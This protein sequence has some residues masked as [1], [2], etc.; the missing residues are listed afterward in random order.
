MSS[1]EYTLRQV[2]EIITGTTDPAVISRVSRQVRH[3]TAED[4]VPTLGGKHGGSG[5]HRRYDANAVRRAAITLE[6]VRYGITITSLEPFDEYLDD[7]ADHPKWEKAVSG[8][9]NVFLS[10][11]IECVEDGNTPI[12]LGT[13]DEADPLRLVEA[14]TEEDYGRGLIEV[15]NY[16]ST[17]VINLTKL[18]ARLDL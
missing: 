4:I 12:G 11:S 16:A 14:Q 18:F 6:L 9:E 8:G 3:W 15:K 17:L 7:I 1:E 2:A 5:V 13:R 10:Y